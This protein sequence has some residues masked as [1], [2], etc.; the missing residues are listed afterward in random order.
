MTTASSVD[1]EPQPFN[2][3]YDLSQD[4]VQLLT[5]RML[6]ERRS[7]FPDRYVCIELD[8][9]DEYSNIARTLER[10]IFEEAFNNDADEMKAEYG[11]YEPASRFFLS[12][13]TETKTPNGVLRIIHNSPMGF[14]TLN[15]LEDPS[16]TSRIMREEDIVKYHNIDDLDACWDVGTVGVPKEF[17]G[18]AGGNISV[19]LYRAWYV[20]AEQNNIEHVVTILDKKPYKQLR[21]FLGVPMKPMLGINKPFSYLGSKE[22]YATYGYVPKFYETMERKR[23]YDPRK[24]MARAVLNRLMDG[25]AIDHKLLF[26]GD[27]KK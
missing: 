18:A 23:R 27:Y 6:S 20:A 12:V 15:D 14:K 24:W 1:Y 17:R 21:D 4:D 7:P 22:S 11:P 9:M 10:E 2:C 25:D 5:E 8:G 19:Q 26:N 3:R 13:D 16:K